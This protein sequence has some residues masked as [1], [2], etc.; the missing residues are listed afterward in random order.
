MLQSFKLG[1]SCR[2]IDSMGT[3]KHRSAGIPATF[4]YRSV[5]HQKAADQLSGI[6][7]GTGPAAF[8]RAGDVQHP[9]GVFVDNIPVRS[10]NQALSHY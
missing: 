9:D 8:T 10:V 3:V 1:R 2:N 7:M 6:R 5:T 4:R